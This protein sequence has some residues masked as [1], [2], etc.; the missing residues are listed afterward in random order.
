MTFDPASIL[1]WR[2]QAVPGAL[3]HGRRRSS[4]PCPA[5]HG[6]YLGETDGGVKIS[7]AQKI[8][9][10]HTDQRTGIVKETRSEEHVMV[11]TRA[12]CKPRWRTWPS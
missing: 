11:E 9:E 10:H 1:V 6:T 5:R 4:P 3:R 12:W 2:G 7:Y 8:D